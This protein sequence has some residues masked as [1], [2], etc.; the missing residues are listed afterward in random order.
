MCNW[1]ADDL[2]TVWLVERAEERIRKA[3]NVA[4]D[5]QLSNHLRVVD[6][7]LWEIDRCGESLRHEQFAHVARCQATLWQTVREDIDPPAFEDDT[8]TD[9][10][11]VD[12]LDHVLARFR[13]APR[14]RATL[15]EQT[16]SD[17]GDCLRVL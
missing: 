11:L 13:E 2:A 14:G 7:Q 8:R 16:P 12:H 9:E 10:K 1:L 17:N 4:T 5:G 6:K 3:A 15:M